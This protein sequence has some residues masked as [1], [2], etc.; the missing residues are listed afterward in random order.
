MGYSKGIVY[1]IDIL[2]SKN[3]GFDESLKINNIFRDELNKV[4]ERHRP[5]SVGRRYV[6]SF[7]DCAYIIYAIKDEYNTDETFCKYIYT[8]LYNTAST[9]AYFVSNGFLCRGGIS[10]GDL[11]FEPDRN[12]I[13][14]PAINEAYLLEQQAKMP[15]LI[16]SD[17]LAKILVEYDTS[18]KLKNEMAALLNGEIILKDTIDGWY[19]L[20]YLNYLIGVGSVGLGTRSFTFNNYYEQVKANSIN[21]LYTQNNHDIIAKHKWHLN[22]LERMKQYNDS[23]HEMNENDL[24]NM[25]LRNNTGQN[26]A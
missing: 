26:G 25:V 13:F 16:V 12:I 14:G 5:T 17:E 4:Q 23:L 20:N 11:Y 21:A 24:V 10:C 6:T 9:V 3:R 22:Y 7:S 15:R 1:F 18:I 19:F 8:S 2:G